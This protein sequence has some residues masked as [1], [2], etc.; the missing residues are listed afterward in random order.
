MALTCRWRSR[1]QHQKR[2]LELSR[3]MSALSNSGHSRSA[4]GSPKTATD[5][6][7]ATKLADSIGRNG[8]GRPGHKSPWEDRGEQ[9]RLRH[10][11]PTRGGQLGIILRDQ[12][13][14]SANDPHDQRFR[15]SA[16]AYLAHRKLVHFDSG[17]GG[18]D[19]GYN[20]LTALI[21]GQLLE[22]C[23]HMYRI[24]DCR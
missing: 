21:F 8:A 15:A 22:T 1:P 3:G 17:S 7:A 13:I 10:A 6:R 20:Q 19:V 18:D 12:F 24:A 23:G 11:L 9:L 16:H 14:H 4:N 2:T 5:H